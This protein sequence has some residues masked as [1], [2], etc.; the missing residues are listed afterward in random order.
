MVGCAREGLDVA[1]EGRQGADE[2]KADLGV[3]SVWVLWGRACVQPETVG[4]CRRSGS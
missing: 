1:E 3:G 4:L 2:E